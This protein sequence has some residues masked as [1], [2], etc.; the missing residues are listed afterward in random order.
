MVPRAR[1]LRKKVRVP[2]LF[3]TA[4]ALAHFDLRDGNGKRMLLGWVSK[5]AVRDRLLKRMCRD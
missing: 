5:S 4:F 1:N 3:G 2:R